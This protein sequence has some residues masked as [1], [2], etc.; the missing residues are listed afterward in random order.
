MPFAAQSVKKEARS[1]T[2]PFIQISKKVQALWI[3]ARIG[4]RLHLSGF[5]IC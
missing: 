5:L 2:A 3:T 4:K 1:E